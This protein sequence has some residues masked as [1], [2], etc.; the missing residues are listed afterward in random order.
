MGSVVKRIRRDIAENEGIA[1]RRSIRKQQ[2]I[3]L[4][5]LQAKARQVGIPDHVTELYVRAAFKRGGHG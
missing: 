4:K 5:R 2:N 1:T 3:R